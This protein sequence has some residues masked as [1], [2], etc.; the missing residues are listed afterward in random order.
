MKRISI[1]ITAYNVEKYINECIDSVVAQKAE[2]DE[3]IVVNDQSTDK[4]L[5]LL[6]EYG[7]HIKVINNNENVGPGMSRRIGIEAAEGEYVLLLDGDDYL[8]PKFLDALYDEAERTDADVVSGGITILNP[9]G[10]WNATSYGHTM[11]EGID[12]VARFWGERIVFM[13]NKIIRR[14]LYDQVP[15]CERR[16]IEDTPTIIPILY[17]ANK[18]S[19]VDHVGYVYRMNDQSLTHTADAVKDIIYKGICWAELVEFF[20]EKDPELFKAVDLAGY[21][22]GLVEAMNSV[23]WSEEAIAP[24]KE[25]WATFMCKL[26]KHIKIRNIDIKL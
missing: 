26:L 25:D 20:G 16:Y 4:T 12:K 1:V 24:Y 14:K 19:Y 8:K 22:K 3:I 11:T 2:N 18:V 9:D 13:N 7:D 23:D 6:K 17:Y 5:D 21:A 10:S 15:Y